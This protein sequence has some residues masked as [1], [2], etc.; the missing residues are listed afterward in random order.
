MDE[1]YDAYVQFFETLERLAADGLDDDEKNYLTKMWDD[2][3]DKI[4]GIYAENGPLQI[5]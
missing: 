3:D 5:L 4:K 1:A 2:I